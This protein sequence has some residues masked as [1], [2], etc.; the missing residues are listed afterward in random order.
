MYNPGC[1]YSFPVAA[2]VFTT[3][4]P[5]AADAVVIVPALNCKDLK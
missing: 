4:V 1:S 5:V 3:A 2:T